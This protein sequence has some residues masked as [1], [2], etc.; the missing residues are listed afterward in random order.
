MKGSTT[1]GQDEV[2]QEDQVEMNELVDSDPEVYGADTE[3]VV[4]R[5]RKKKRSA[6][7]DELKNEIKNYLIDLN[8]ANVNIGTGDDN[9]GIFT[10]PKA[11]DEKIFDNMF[12]PDVV[13]QKIQKRVDLIKNQEKRQMLSSITLSV[14]L[15]LLI[16]LNLII[17]IPVRTISLL[18]LPNISDLWLFKDEL[19]DFDV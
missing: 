7:K 17:P 5:G 6:E 13:S 15:I 11:D 18:L 3:D 8:K 9:G 1:A 12:D 19:F 2:G 16:Q 14:D 10:G 4:P